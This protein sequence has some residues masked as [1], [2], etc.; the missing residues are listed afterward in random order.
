MSMKGI[1]PGDGGRKC[2]T[3]SLFHDAR[4]ERGVTVI[5]YAAIAGL[6]SIAAAGVLYV[7]GGDLSA[8]YEGFAAA[9]P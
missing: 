5:E 3:L 7:I 1:A 6:I 9:F 4:A 2:E 8:A